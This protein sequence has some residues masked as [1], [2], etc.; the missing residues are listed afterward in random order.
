[1][2]QL[3]DNGKINAKRASTNKRLASGVYIVKIENQSTRV[4]IK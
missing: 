3:I 1:M 4:I 2:G